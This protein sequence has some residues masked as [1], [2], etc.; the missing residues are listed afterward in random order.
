[1]GLY[2]EEYERLGKGHR[3]TSPGRTVAEGDINLFAGLT[4]DIHPL[5]TDA[6][7]AKASPYGARIAH[8]Y[9]TASLASGLAYRVG[10]DEGTSQAV[11]STAWKFPAPVMLG[12][13]LR[14]VI[15]LVDLRPSRKH[16]TMGIVTR[17]YDVENQR[18]DVVAVGD[19]AILCKRRPA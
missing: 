9:F 12:D 2:F 3:W 5:H 10:L 14:V 4:G 7:Y 19:I 13:T 6:E 18:G 11:L 17:R 16:P 1:M 15:T 8:G